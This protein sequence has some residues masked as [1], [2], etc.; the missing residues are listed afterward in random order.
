[1]SVQ[2]VIPNIAVDMVNGGGGSGTYSIHLHSKTTANSHYPIVFDTL[3]VKKMNEGNSRNLSLGDSSKCPS[4][5][6]MFL[7]FP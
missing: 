1:M 6:V 5:W 4:F 3:C 2:L 7:C